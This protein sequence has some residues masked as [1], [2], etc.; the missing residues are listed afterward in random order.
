VAFRTRPQS[1]EALKKMLFGDESRF[2]DS[3]G[4]RDSFSTWE[5]AEKVFYEMNGKK[6]AKFE[7]VFDAIRHGYFNGYP[8]WNDP[9]YKNEDGR[10][11]FDKINEDKDKTAK[12]IAEEFMDRNKGCFY[13]VTSYSDNDGDLGC[14][15]EHDGLFDRLPHLQIS[16]H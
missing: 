3:R 7:E 14:A 13:F 1:I 16:H 6:N 12:Q 8:N 9:K 11:N 2:G 4:E 5:I 10:T 15:M